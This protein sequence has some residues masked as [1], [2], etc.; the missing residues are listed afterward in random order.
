MDN[1]N[2][3]KIMSYLSNTND[4]EELLS[5]CIGKV[6]S[7][8]IEFQEYL[9][10]YQRWNVDI[11]K[12]ELLIDD[13][14][15]D[16]SFIGT[17]SKSDGKWFNADLERIPE[18]HLRALLDAYKNIEKY[19]L[20]ELLPKK[21]R[22]ADLHTDHSLAII[23]TALSGKNTC[24]FKG[25]GDVSLFM[26]FNELPEALV[27]S[28][29]ANKFANRIISIVKTFDVK[30]RLL[31]KSFAISNGNNFAEEGD[32]IVVKFG[33]E[34]SLTFKFDDVGRVANISGNL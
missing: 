8:Q 4:F 16:V 22:L 18:E 28:V 9:G 25:S 6:Y 21:I 2:M 26:V 23:Y 34:S 20:S 13:K 24:Y 32:S 33:S 31:I 17:T 15:F 19:G 30:H 7:N 12:G 29:D 5:V 10:N 3:D 14:K 11:T 27:K 1:N